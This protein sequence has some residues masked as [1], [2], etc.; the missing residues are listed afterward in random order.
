[1]NNF[2]LNTIV[3]IKRAPCKTCVTYVY[4]LP[5]ALDHDFEEIFNDFGVFKYNV[6][7]TNI[8]SIEDKDGYKVHG[9]I[10]E[11]TIKFIAPLEFE[12]N[13]QSKKLQFDKL[14]SLWLENKLGITIEVL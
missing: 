7:H 2:K 9:K 8:I 14:L 4:G 13:H 11:T 6:K 1:M 3:S 10:K 12:N 5:S